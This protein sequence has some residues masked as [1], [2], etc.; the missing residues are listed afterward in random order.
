[1]RLRLST[2][3]TAI[4]CGTLLVIMVIFAL[5]HVEA[6]KESFFNEAVYEAD[7]LSEMLQRATYYQM[8]EDDRTS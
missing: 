1:M 7:T 4:S 2:K 3:F 6:L 5:I 8:L